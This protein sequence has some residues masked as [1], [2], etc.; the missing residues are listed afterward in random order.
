LRGCESPRLAAA[1]AACV[2]SAKRRR[3]TSMRFCTTEATLAE[4]SVACTARLTASG[5][6]SRV[7]VVFMG[8]PSLS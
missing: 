7:L 4:S 8:L 1:N 5:G 6:D 3:A 2:R